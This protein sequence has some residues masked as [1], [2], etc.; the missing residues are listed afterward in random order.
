MATRRA[1]V[2][3][4]ESPVWRRANRPLLSECGVPDAV[5]DSDRRWVYVLLHGDDYFGTGWDTSWISPGQAARLLDG[6]LSD[7]PGESGYGLVRCLRHRS[8]ERD[9]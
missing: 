2:A 5:A 7:S 6:L 1:T 9:A 8:S 3:G 4:V